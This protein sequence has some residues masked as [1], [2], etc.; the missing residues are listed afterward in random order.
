[1]S[2]NNQITRYAV[3]YIRISDRKQIEGESPVTQRKVI[4]QYAREN[5]I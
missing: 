5:N 3:A 1:M 4:E 2:S